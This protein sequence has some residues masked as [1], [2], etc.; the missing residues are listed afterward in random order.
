LLLLGAGPAH[1]ALLRLWARQPPGGLEVLALVSAAERQRL[2]PLASAASVPLL[3]AQP[4][5]W[6]AATRRIPLADG[7]AADYE[8]LSLA[9]TPATS[10]DALPGARGQALFAQPAE[11][12][13]G[14][15]PGLDEL[16]AQRV[17]DVVVIGGGIT[18]CELALALQRRLSAGGSERARVALVLGAERPL[19]QAPAWPPGAVQRL[20]G[21]LAARRITLFRE[22][23]SAIEPGA[24]VL[25]SGAR[26]A[27][28][29]PVLATGA[30]PPPWLAASG[31]ALDEAG[32]PQAQATLQSPSHAE[33]L[34][35]RHA[36]VAPLL[37]AN[38]QRLA[39]GVA[40][41]PGRPSRSG[42]L[43]LDAGDGR[44]LF[45]WGPWWEGGRLA[46]WCRRRLTPSA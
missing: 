36:A 8:L 7:R 24:V 42:P 1:E 28:D 27:C 32:W 25:A 37:A 12:L 19:A 43:W 13:R 16:A 14:L 38:L 45:A 9:P 46:G 34:V 30:A 33:V 39:S 22:R 10:R 6:D 44:A 26:L 15:L 5:A 2:A 21:W 11:T 31:L 4:V 23:A 17:I 20:L 18:G 3:E 40:L 35:A 41:Q 29:A